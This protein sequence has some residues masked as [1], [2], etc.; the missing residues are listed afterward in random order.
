VRKRAHVGEDHE[1][2][3]DTGEKVGHGQNQ[4]VSWNLSMS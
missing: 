3:Q 4:R 1:A 2:G